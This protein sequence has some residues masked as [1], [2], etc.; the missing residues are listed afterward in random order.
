MPSVLRRRGRKSGGLRRRGRS[1]LSGDLLLAVGVGLALGAGMALV[2]RERARRRRPMARL[3][4]FA[5]RGVKEARR[6]RD[7]GAKWA[8]ERGDALRD[9]V[10][11]DEIGD[12][13]AEYLESARESIDAA[14]NREIRDLRKAIRRQ[15]K[16]LG[17]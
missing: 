14:V 6:L 1:E 4:R 15:R 11:V 2:A 8:A 9:G 3:E 12:S 13:V 5:E 7:R 17:V 16:R 10:P